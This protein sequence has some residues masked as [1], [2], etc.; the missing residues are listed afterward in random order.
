MSTMAN[1]GEE[2][3]AIRAPAQSG[4]LGASAY[5]G[6]P[7]NTIVTLLCLALLA[8]AAKVAV[9]W[10][11]INAV[12]DGTPEDC[13]ASV[14]ACWPYLTAKLRYMLFG[15][16][17]FEEQWRPLTATALFILAI[18]ISCIPRLWSRWLLL[19]WVVL[20]P[21]LYLLM[22]GGAFG[23]AEVPTS[24]WGGLPLSFM[25]TFVGLVCALPLGILLALARLSNL[26]AI[27][28]LAVTFIELVRGVPLISILFMASVML[29]LFMPDG[30]TI[31]KLLRAQVAIILFA[32]AYIAEIVRAGLQ[33]LPRGQTEAAQALGLHYWQ[34]TFLVI[35]PQALKTVIPPLV[36][37]FIGFFQDTTLVTIVG[38]LDF[39]NTVRTALRDPNWQGIAVL[40]GYLF[41]AAVYF[42]FSALM[43]AYSRF[44]EKHFRVGYD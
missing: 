20:L 33:A 10:L 44:L 7:A 25:L 5:F 4:G 24:Q 31:D 19:G 17:P 1:S 11:V 14:G 28:I 8:L 15:I 43:G 2:Q 41:A 42:V 39:L 6:T 35:I 37:L 34:Y 40:E 38:L 30:V 26:P 9:S 32:A 3:I 29:P 27:R 22:A 12:F 23:L 13:K 16:Y 21:V 18:T 36:S